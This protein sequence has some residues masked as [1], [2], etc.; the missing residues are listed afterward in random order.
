[1]D[2]YDANA[3]IKHIFQGLEPGEEICVAISEEDWYSHTEFDSPECQKWLAPDSGEATYVAIST[4]KSRTSGRLKR[5][6]D[7]L[8]TQYCAILDDAGTGPGS[9]FPLEDI[10][11]KPTFIVETSPNNHQVVY[12]LCPNSERDRHK[13]WFD[14]TVNLGLNDKGAGGAG[15]VMRLPGSKNKKPQNNGFKARIVE[16][17][18]DIFYDW[19]DMFEGFGL[20][21]ALLSSSTSGAAK[22]VLSDQDLDLEPNNPFLG[23]LYEQGLV[24]EDSGD[25]FL[26]IECPNHH[27]HSDG[28]TS[29]RYS[30]VGRGADQFK[31]Y[32]G[33]MCFHGHC[34][35]LSYDDFMQLFAA[36]GAPVV[37]K[38]DPV[39]FL[40]SR[41]VYVVTDQR[42][43]D[44][45]QRPHGGVWLK[46]FADFSKEF[47][48]RVMVPGHD[49]PV[50]LANAW[51][52]SKYTRKVTTVGY[53]P[54]QN[55]IAVNRSQEIVNSYIPPLHPWTK[56][57]PRVTL[58]HLDYLVPNELERETLLDWFACK[59]QRPET[60]SYAALLVAKNA[61]GTGRGW[62]KNLLSQMLPNLV[63][64]IT[65]P[66]LINKGSQADANYNDIF[67]EKQLL[68]ADEAKE[69]EGVDFFTGYETIKTRIDQSPIAFRVNP[70]FGRTRTDFMYFNCLIFSNHE[71]AINLPQDDR[72]FFVVTN[73]TKPK[74]AEYYERLFAALEDG[75]EA[76]RFY[77]Y[78]MR[79]D[80]S[81]F[82]RAK[83]PMTVGKKV[84][85]QSSLSPSDEILAHL[86]DTLP[87]DLITRKTLQTRVKLAAR[88]LGFDTVER[89]PGKTTRR[90]WRE[91]GS[92]SPEDRNGLR[93]SMDTERLEIR[94][95]RNN[96]EWVAKLSGSDRELFAAEAKKN[97][98]ETAQ[99]AMAR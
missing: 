66:Q 54:G 50:L 90:I 8:H 39:A 9:K 10:P 47:Y 64:A 60:R 58:D 44:M 19:N 89:E 56:E 78:L 17:N 11:L 21:E 83:P 70:K 16:F 36:K 81:N 57:E 18:P 76:Q 98:P 84:M 7:S 62:L 20:D 15:R 26:S 53:L 74:S 80:I 37:P 34:Q 99:F 95:L 12:V 55:A 86:R 24:L 61:F 45:R 52:E 93:V 33:L 88:A 69:T 2:Q 35:D 41:Y 42:V 87:G 49:R 65:L 29:M 28:K 46:S 67:S 97:S 38:H 27:N 72:R 5:T 22:R 23:W 71:H 32:H 25:D 14:G 43:A 94:A 30:P 48:S 13:A 6:K 31:E 91:I 92:L 63:G 79:R 1:M 85:I 77:W 4:V 40:Q 96:R 75:K 73:P 68:I 51:L 3:F 82:N 59:L